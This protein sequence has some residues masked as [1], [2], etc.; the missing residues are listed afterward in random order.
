VPVS[1]NPAL[2]TTTIIALAFAS[3]AIL[4]ALLSVFV[5]ASRPWGCSV[6]SQSTA[7]S[8]DWVTS[9][10]VAAIWLVA[11]LAISLISFKR[12]ALALAVISIPLMAFSE[13]SFAGLFTLAPAALWLAC[14]LWLWSRDRRLRIALSAIASVALVWVGIS[15]VLGLVYLSTAAI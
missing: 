8:C 12:W 5:M 4:A 10:W 6:S 9:K 13:L 15:G 14:A 3:L 2:R 7:I 1:R 11:A